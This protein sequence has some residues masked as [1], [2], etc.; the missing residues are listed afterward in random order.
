MAPPA[1]AETTI[2]NP[3]QF[4]CPTFAPEPKPFILLILNQP[5]RHLL[6]FKHLWHHASLRICGDGGANRL[7][8]AFQDPHERKDF[9]PKAICGDLDSL[10]E[11]VQEYY[12]TLGT[13]I[14]GDREDQESTDFDKC[15]K[16]IENYYSGQADPI[17]TTMTIFVYNS[18]GGR[19]DHAF[20]SLNQLYRTSGTPLTATLYLI[21]EDGLTILLSR[22]PNTIFLPA[23]FYGPSCGIIPI[24]GPSIITTKG[25][26]WDV[27]QWE[28]RFGGRISTSNVLKEEI[29]TVDTEERVL[30]SV[31][32]K[33][34]GII[35]LK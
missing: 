13:E 24:G 6:F 34:E 33:V 19:L 4:I 1:A 8:D 26:V 20:H 21:S 27:E 3:N 25:L 30:F 31:E 22:G 9:V 10:R 11:D 14:A 16:Y 29:V 2:W 18:L 15:L 12:S 23:I 5:I 32:V 7:Y 35:G 17:T 28:T